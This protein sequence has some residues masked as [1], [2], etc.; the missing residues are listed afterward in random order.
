MAFE[1]VLFYNIWYRAVDKL[2]CLPTQLFPKRTVCC[3]KPW[4]ASSP[5]G[6]GS[7]PEASSPSPWFGTVSPDHQVEELQ[8][9][10]YPAATVNRSLCLMAKAFLYWIKFFNIT[11]AYWLLAG[12]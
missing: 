9:T 5:I 2:M 12:E 3:K 1:V 8:T 11:M 10:T 7:V 4:G 6:V